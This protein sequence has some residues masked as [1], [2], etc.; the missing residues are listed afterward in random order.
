MNVTYTGK[1]EKFYPTQIR[2]MDVKFGKLAKLLDGNKG[3]KQAHVIL[4]QNKKGHSAEITVN[5]L[6]HALVGSAADTDQF[7][8]VTAAIDKL[9][10]QVLKIRT[11]RRDTK[12][13]GIKMAVAKRAKNVK[14]AELEEPAMPAPT[15]NGARRVYRVNHT[16]D[17]KPMTLEEALIEIEKDG[18]YVVYRDA[19]NDR[20]SVLLRRSDGHFDLIEG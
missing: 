17:R 9:E 2:K 14:P 11:K 20:L 13:D 3:E 6:D 12:R 8:A 1:Q 5:Y 4:T 16:A 7:T 18:E 10:K 15:A 19:R